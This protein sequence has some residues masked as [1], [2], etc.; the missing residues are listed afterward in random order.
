I[1]TSY[2]KPG[3]NVTAYLKCFAGIPDAGAS[4]SVNLYVDLPINDDPTQI[5]NEIT[6]AVGHC[7][8]SLTKTGSGQS[9][10]QYFGFASTQPF[11]AIVGTVTPGKVV[12]NSGHKFNGAYAMPV[13]AT[14]F[15]VAMNSINRLS[16]SNYDLNNFNCIDFALSVVN[17]FQPTT[18]IVPAPMQMPA[19]GI[20]IDTPQGLYITL[21]HIQN[22]G[23][24]AFVGSI[25]NAGTS[26]GACN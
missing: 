14:Q 7:F 17:S 8:L 3:I 19:A 13:N 12:D 9:V 24:A 23:G 18:P 4:Y 6:G 16:T 11:S 22:T 20:S 1:E 25:W 2:A 15:A 26:H 5:F 21:Q 10:T